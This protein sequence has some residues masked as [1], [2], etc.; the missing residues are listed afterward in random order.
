MKIWSLPLIF[1]MGCSFLL[2]PSAPKNYKPNKALSCDTEP[3]WPLV[4]SVFAVSSAVAT[5]AMPF[6]KVNEDGQIDPN[7]EKLQGQDLALVLA[8]TIIDATVFGLSARYGFIHTKRCQAAQ[9]KYRDA[10]SK[11]PQ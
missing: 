9:Q 1:L 8:N 5:V 7:G 11:A 2:T 6:V 10:H 4:D 3:T